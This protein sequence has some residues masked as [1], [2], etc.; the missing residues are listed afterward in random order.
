MSTS[1]SRLATLLR[2]RESE[3]DQRRTELF[4]AVHSLDIVRKQLT[5]LAQEAQKIQRLT[6]ESSRPGSLNVNRLLNS[7]RYDLL[8][9]V[10]HQQLCQRESALTSLVERRREMV[11]DADREVRILEKLIEKEDD[12]RRLTQHHLDQQLQDEAARQVMFA[13]NS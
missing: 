12:Q 13:P 6:R 8:L 7:H 4:H 11:V 1:N 3:R 9:E 2:V 10:R 5:E